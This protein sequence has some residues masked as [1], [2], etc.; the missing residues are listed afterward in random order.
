MG[1]NNDQVN[2]SYQSTDASVNAALVYS[3]PQHSSGTFI[4]QV[5]A[6]DGSQNTGSW[7]VQFSG[8]RVSGNCIIVGTPI[9][10]PVGVDLALALSA[11]TVSVFGSS[12][13]INV[14]GI[15]LLTVNWDISMKVMYDNSNG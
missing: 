2:A 4:A 3:F 9:V 1:I 13:V 7:Q 12:F 5:L 11:V 10:T 8:K 15:S 14:A 6:F